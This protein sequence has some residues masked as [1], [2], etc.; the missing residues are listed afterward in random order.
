MKDVINDRNTEY[1]LSSKIAE[2]NYTYFDNAGKQ[3]CFGAWH[4]FNDYLLFIMSYEEKRRLFYDSIKNSPLFNKIEKEF[5][6]NEFISLIRLN[7]DN[8]SELTDIQKINLTKL[9]SKNFLKNYHD[10]KSQQL[11]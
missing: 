3:Y 11:R 8:W 2:I 6:I 4:N 7:N 5:I 1:V 9:L 10:N